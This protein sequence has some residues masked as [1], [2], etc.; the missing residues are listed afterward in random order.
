MFEYS[1]HLTTVYLVASVF[2]FLSYDGT[3]RSTSI[4]YEHAQ[5][6][7]TLQDDYLGGSSYAFTT[8]NHYV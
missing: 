5:P 3:C 6:P 1:A 8:V 2:F 7:G 4:H